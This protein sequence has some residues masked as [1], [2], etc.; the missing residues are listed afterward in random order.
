MWLGEAVKTFEYLLVK[1]DLQGGQLISKDVAG[2][3]VMER[4]A[5]SGSGSDVGRVI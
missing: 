3:V 1:F 5:E 2:I 4:G